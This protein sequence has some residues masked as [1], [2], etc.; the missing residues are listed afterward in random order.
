QNDADAGCRLRNR[1]YRLAGFQY[2]PPAADTLIVHDLHIA[3]ILRPRRRREL[4]RLAI[5]EHKGNIVERRLADIGG[6]MCARTAVG[7]SGVGHAASL[8]PFAAG[9]LGRRKILVRHIGGDAVERYAMFSWR[10]VT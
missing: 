3:G 5:P 1:R 2:Q 4:P 9:Y 6:L 10:G 7:I 8:R